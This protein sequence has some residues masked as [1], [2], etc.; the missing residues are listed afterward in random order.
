ML[1]EGGVIAIKHR[2][3]RGLYKKGRVYDFIAMILYLMGLVHERLSF[4]NNGI[5]RRLTNVHGHV[6]QEV[7]A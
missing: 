7:V 2:S 3:H 6:I 5:E 1:V 4:Y